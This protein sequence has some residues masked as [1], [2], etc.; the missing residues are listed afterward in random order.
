[1]SRAKYKKQKNFILSPGLRRSACN[2]E[3][4][5]YHK[6]KRQISPVFASPFRSRVEKK[7]R[8]LPMKKIISRGALSLLFLGAAGCASI[9]EPPVHSAPLTPAIAMPPWLEEMEQQNR[10]RVF[11]TDEEKMRFAIELASQNVLHGTGGPFGAAIFEVKTGRL[12]AVG[13]NRVV[14]AGQSWAH[15][16]MTAFARAQHLRN[17]FN[18]KGCLL[19]TSCEPCAMCY[20]ATPWSGVEAMLYGATRED[21]EAIGFDE[22]DKGSDWVDALR[23]RNIDVRGPLLR[24]EAKRPFTLYRGK[25][26]TIY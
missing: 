26:G 6:K 5:R 23:K 12:V 3:F 15:A 16:E 9:P 13:V 1:M 4:R 20:G 19:A 24:E 25:A 11:A 8:I 2:P 17:S 21:A 18:L 10:N 7:E 22:G 14:P